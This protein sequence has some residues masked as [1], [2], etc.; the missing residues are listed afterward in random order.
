MSSATAPKRKASGADDD[1][2]SGRARKSARATVGEEGATKA[3]YPRASQL[4]A[5]RSQY[6]HTA[7][8]YAIYA[9]LIMLARRLLSQRS[10][11]RCRHSSLRTSLSR[12]FV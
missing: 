9:A 12:R 5:N 10:D 2:T 11:L 1:E 7:R 6:L 8:R 3:S 4:E